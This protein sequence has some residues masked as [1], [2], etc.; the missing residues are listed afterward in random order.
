MGTV[1]RGCPCRKKGLVLLRLRSPAP[2]YVFLFS[3]ELGSD[4]GPQRVRMLNKC[5]VLTD[6]RPDPSL[7]LTSKQGLLRICNF[8]S[9]CLGSVVNES[10]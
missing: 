10:D 1:T 7:L 6:G 3:E 9:S 4:I 8:R 2:S 5:L